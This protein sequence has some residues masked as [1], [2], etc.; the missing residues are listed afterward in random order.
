[1]SIQCELILGKLHPVS[2]EQDNISSYTITA[3]FRSNFKSSINLEIL[4]VK[5]VAGSIHNRVCSLK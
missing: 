3:Y 5:L 4:P 1:M 2:Q